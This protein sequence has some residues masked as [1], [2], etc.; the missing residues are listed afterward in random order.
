MDKFA[1]YL[2]Y[3]YKLQ[4]YSTENNNNED[5]INYLNIFL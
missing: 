5:N 2:D 4:E 3:A 1:F